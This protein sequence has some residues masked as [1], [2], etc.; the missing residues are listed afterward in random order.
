VHFIG[1]EKG[2]FIELKKIDEIIHFQHLAS[3]EVKGLMEKLDLLY[4]PTI[5]LIQGQI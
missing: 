5:E 1:D 4:Y 2:Y 3:V